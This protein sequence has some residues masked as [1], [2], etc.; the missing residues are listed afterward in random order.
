MPD[1]STFNGTKNILPQEYVETL[2]VGDVLNNEV[3][4]PLVWKRGDSQVVK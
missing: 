4:N 3:Q 1:G 2:S